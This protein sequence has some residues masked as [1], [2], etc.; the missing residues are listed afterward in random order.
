MPVIGFTYALLAG[1]T[2]LGAFGYETVIAGR[3]ENLQLLKTVEFGL[4]LFALVQMTSLIHAA[5]YGSRGGQESVALLTKGGLAKWFLP[6]VFGAGFIVPALMIPFAGSS[7]AL[8]VIAL[9][10]L[11]GYYTFRVLVFKAGMYDPVQ[12]FRSRTRRF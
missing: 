2:L 1:T 8:Q 11:A 10:V 6:W 5:R 7:A 9:A 4:V 3:P 12:S